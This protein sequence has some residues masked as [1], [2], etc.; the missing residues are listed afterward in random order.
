VNA[1]ETAEM[2]R[3]YLPDEYFGEPAAFV[4]AEQW[5]AINESAD[6]KRIPMGVDFTHVEEKRAARAAHPA[7]TSLE[8][9]G[10]ALKAWLRL[11]P[12]VDRPAEAL[13]VV[14][15][16]PEAQRRPAFWKK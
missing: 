16:L 6:S 2:M 1:P 10:H 8:A 4:L 11:L 7:A 14:T 12:F 5:I 3:A 9:E 15:G 13:A